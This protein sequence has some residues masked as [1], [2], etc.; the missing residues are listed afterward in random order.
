MEIKI[1]EWR[2]ED[3]SNAYKNGNIVD[4]K[5]YAL[6]KQESFCCSQKTHVE[7][8]ALLSKVNTYKE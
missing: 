7:T 2:I 1:R 5:M 3:K 4:M 8:V 6:V